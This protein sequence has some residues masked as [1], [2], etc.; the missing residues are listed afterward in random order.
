MVLAAFQV[1]P[2]IRLGRKSQRE[3]TDTVHRIHQLFIG[4]FNIDIYLISF[5]VIKI[6][7]D[8]LFGSPLFLPQGRMKTSRVTVQI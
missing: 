8:P 4:F 1:F 3:Q 7:V 6:E 5:F 2:V